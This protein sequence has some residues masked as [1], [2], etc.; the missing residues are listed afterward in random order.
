MMLFYKKRRGC[1][2]PGMLWG[3]AAGLLIGAF[4]VMLGGRERMEKIKKL[5]SGCLDKCCSLFR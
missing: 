1:F 5:G 4:G 2:V 3:L